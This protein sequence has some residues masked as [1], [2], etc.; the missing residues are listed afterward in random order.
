MEEIIPISLTKEERD[1]LNKSAADVRQQI[2]VLK[3]QKK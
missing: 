2:D 1:A 3:N